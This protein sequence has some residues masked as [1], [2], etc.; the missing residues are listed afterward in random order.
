MITRSWGEQQGNGGEER[1]GRSDRSKV[2]HVV[3][4]VWL[5]PW[6]RTL[7]SFKWPYGKYPL[8]QHG[9]L[10]VAICWRLVALCRNV[11]LCDVEL[12][13]NRISKENFV[14]SSAGFEYYSQGIQDT[15]LVYV[16]RHI[17]PV[18]EHLLGQIGAF[19]K[20]SAPQLS[21]EHKTSWIVYRH[22]W[23]NR[24]WREQT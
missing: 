24:I 18:W 22:H 2:S 5:G 7:H 17:T 11:I 1:R 12:F 20:S 9:F 14:L 23:E 16:L 10:V 6:D 13:P 15:A 4:C 3:V 21:V 19:L 8:L